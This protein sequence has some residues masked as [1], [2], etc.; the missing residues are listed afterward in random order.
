MLPD[1]DPP[2]PSSPPSAD[3]TKLTADAEALA[4]L[5]RSDAW[6]TF[7][8]P[9]LGEDALN[10]KAGAMLL[11]KL[12]E[13][14]VLDHRAVHRALTEMRMGLEK[15]LQGMITVL[16]QANHLS[17]KLIN[18]RTQPAEPLATN[19]PQESG[20]FDPFAENPK[21]ATKP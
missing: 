4:D 17:L 7:I 20:F 11:D 10:A 21:P 14:T 16:G 9:Y 1:R 2:N 6:K 5:L 3:L 19:L 15:Q 8:L 18:V 13:R 12:D